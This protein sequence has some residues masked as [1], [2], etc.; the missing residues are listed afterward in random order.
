MINQFL[1]HCARV[2]HAA[3]APLSS[4]P[5]PGSRRRCT[6]SREVRREA[7]VQGLSQGAFCVLAGDVAMGTHS[8]WLIKTQTPSATTP[9]CFHPISPAVT[10]TMVSG[11]TGVAALELEVELGIHFSFLL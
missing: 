10:L 6:Q 8:H 9:V 3:K 5:T 2:N 4:P 11:H 7:Q 1:V